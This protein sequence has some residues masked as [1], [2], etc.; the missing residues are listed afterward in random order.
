M[1]SNMWI[2]H[3]CLTNVILSFLVSINLTSRLNG[4]W[5]L[6]SQM[7]GLLFLI[8]LSKHKK[9]NYQ[10]WVLFHKIWD[11]LCFPPENKSL[12]PLIYKIQRRYNFKRQSLYQFTRLLSM[13][14]LTAIM[15]RTRAK[16]SKK[17]I[18]FLSHPWEFMQ[19]NQ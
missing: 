12:S 13:Q 14:V 17:A 9:M 15:K 4:L 18:V 5:K 19:R 3:G 11:K 2:Q 8:N 1:K 6:S 7:T 16:Q 10:V